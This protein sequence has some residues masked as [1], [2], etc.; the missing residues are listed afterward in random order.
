M[1]AIKE[2]KRPKDIN[3]P[4]FDTSNFRT[5]FAIAC[6]KAGLGTWDEESGTRTGVR[7]HDCR[8]SGAINLLASGVDKGL[9]LKVGGWKTRSVLDR[10]NVA[11]ITRLTAAM[12]KG[13]K[14]LTDRIAVAG[15]TR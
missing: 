13:S 14:F 6:A 5:E 3:A 1:S 7:I 9:V 11:D 4:L 12:E 8:A 15:A 2:L 10:Y